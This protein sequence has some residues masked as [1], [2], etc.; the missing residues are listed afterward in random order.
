VLKKYL[1]YIIIG[2][3]FLFIGFIIRPGRNDSNIEAR[4]SKLEGIST[5]I[6]TAQQSAD[7]SIKSIESS[8]GSISSNTIGLSNSYKR[9]ESGIGK[10][11]E[12]DKRTTEIIGG[13]VIRNTELEK[14][15]REYKETT[16]GFGQLIERIKERN[17]EIEN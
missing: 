12:N 8:I 11:S 15:S 1:P 5:E 16:D 13:L 14:L 10:L 17:K 7:V 9:I 3:I 2:A 6:R 4:I